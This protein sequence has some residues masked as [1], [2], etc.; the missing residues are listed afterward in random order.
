MDVAAAA[1][2]VDNT[3]VVKEQLLH[4]VH[5]IEVVAAVVQVVDILVVDIEDVV[6]G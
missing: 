5:N 4:V 1:F 2:V 6:V 3:I